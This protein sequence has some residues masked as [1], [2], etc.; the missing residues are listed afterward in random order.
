MLSQ[1]MSNAISEN[2]NVGTLGLG[3]KGL[4]SAAVAP[5]RA[6]PL[7]QAELEVLPAPRWMGLGPPGV[8]S[9]EILRSWMEE[10]ERV[11]V[12]DNEIEHAE[13]GLLHAMLTAKTSLDV[14]PGN[15]RRAFNDARTRANPFEG[16]KKEFFMNRAALKMA[17]MDAAFNGMF[18]FADAPEAWKDAITAAAAEADGGTAIRPAPSLLYFGD[19]AAGPGGFSE[20]MLWRRGGSAMGFGFT[21]RG[22]HD[23]T[24]GKFHYRAS[25]ELFHPYYGPNNDGDLYNSDNIR[26]FRGV[27]ARG[28]GGHMLHVLMGDGGFDVSGLEN[29]QEVASC[30]SEP[31]YNPQ[32]AYYVLYGTWCIVYGG[33]SMVHVAHCMLHTAYCMQHGAYGMVHIAWYMVHVA[34][35]M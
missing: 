16:I 9:A 22:D 5:G 20:Y 11:E 19:V 8:P 10:G 33:C 32:S 6:E 4:Q 7:T 1:G 12:L 13:P 28:T 30:C 35:C 24:P 31:I 23:F 34:Y 18:G 3:F 2:S 14:I 29:I 25:P 17:A 27:V 15:Q 21:L 26:A